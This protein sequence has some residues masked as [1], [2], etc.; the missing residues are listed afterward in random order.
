MKT[1]IITMPT[2]PVPSLIQSVAMRIGYLLSEKT[3]FVGTAANMV[4]IRKR[5]RPENIS[6]AVHNLLGSKH[7]LDEEEIELLEDF[8]S[9]QKIFNRT[10]NKPPDYI[11]R[12]KDFEHSIWTLYDA[13]IANTVETIDRPEMSGLL[14][15]VDDRFWAAP[16]NANNSE[17]DD[18]TGFPMSNM[19]YPAVKDDVL[20]NPILFTDFMLVSDMENYKKYRTEQGLGNVGPD[21]IEKPLLSFPNLN[22]LNAEELRILHGI[23]QPAAAQWCATVDPWLI[24]VD[25][26]DMA[27]ASQLAKKL[28]AA[29]CEMQQAIDNA[30]LIKRAKQTSKYE[31][32]IQLC[33]GTMLFTDLWHCYQHDK[34]MRPE[35]WEALQQQLA[36]RPEL[37]ERRIAFFF[38]HRLDHELDS[39]EQAIGKKYLDI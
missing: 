21:I 15:L 39:K 29:C 31:N 17:T 33:A 5:K 16:I 4:M 22:Q 7:L 38:L 23:L 28:D 12:F 34:T 32:V 14:P 2:T 24:S 1:Y 8:I 13:I 10:K 37:R 18:D 35:T 25:N 11:W 30:P 6:K 36:K 27:E 9:K 3:A 26:S 20:F 19:L